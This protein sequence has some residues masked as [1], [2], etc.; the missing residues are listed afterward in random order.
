MLA[1][2]NRENGVGAA[3]A[4][5]LRPCGVIAYGRT[6]ARFTRAV[7]NPVNLNLRDKAA[8]AAWWA[9]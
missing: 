9:C 7:R 2:C 6:R 8:R 1:I 3:R 4:L 5:L